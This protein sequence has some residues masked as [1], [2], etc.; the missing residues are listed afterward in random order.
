VRQ[1]SD[2]WSRW[3]NATISDAGASSVIRSPAVGSQHEAHHDE[4][5]PVD[6]VAAD[7]SENSQDEQH[8]A[9][10]CQNQVYDG[11]HAAQRNI[12]SCVQ[13]GTR[14]RLASMTTDTDRVLNV[15]DAVALG[16]IVSCMKGRGQVARLVDGNVLVGTARSV[17]DENGNFAAQLD[18][19]RDCYLRVTLR[20]GFEAFWPVSELVQEMGSY[21]VVGYEG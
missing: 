4:D 20:S 11:W 21:F 5:Q 8:Q 17:G 18:D 7:Q 15:R 19:V 14:C 13:G 12:A 1:V 9:D 2:L 10:E 3:R 16:Q 6:Q